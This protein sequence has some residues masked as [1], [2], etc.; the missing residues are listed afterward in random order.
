MG[1]F[2]HQVALGD[3][4][5]GFQCRSR[6]H[7][8]VAFQGH[9]LFDSGVLPGYGVGLHHDVG[10]DVGAVLQLDV[11]SQVRVVAHLAVGAQARVRAY[12]RVVTDLHMPFGRCETVH[13]D[14]RSQTR[15]LSDL[16]PVLEVAH[17][18]DVRIP[19]DL[20]LGFQL[21]ALA[22]DRSRFYLP[23]D[24]ALRA[25]ADVRSDP[26]VLAGLDVVLHHA[27]LTDGGSLCH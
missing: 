13:G 2:L 1:L 6:S 21:Y 23:V 7:F 26:G 5:A 25:D 3:V 24:R 19:A 20:C 8:G 16:C 14:A 10:A 17:S 18:L 9:A 11:L 15:Q 12:D 27:V 22:Y 4:C